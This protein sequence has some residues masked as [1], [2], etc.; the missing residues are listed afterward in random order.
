MKMPKLK[1][2]SGA[3]KRF[4][5]TASGKVKIPVSRKRHNMRKRGNRFLRQATGTVIAAEGDA[6][7]IKR[8]FL[9]NA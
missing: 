4:R 9:P 8:Y 6:R 3:K 2:K 7:N 1:T 5:L